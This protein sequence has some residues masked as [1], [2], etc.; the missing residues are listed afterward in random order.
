M[1]Q[2][3]IDDVPDG[4]LKE[5]QDRADHFKQHVEDVARSILVHAVASDHWRG[6]LSIEELLER[7]RKVRERHP[8]AWI[9]EEFLRNAKNDGR[10]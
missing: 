3:T 4:I 5:L 8:D 10:A 9:T 1:A 7:A 6:E 2:L